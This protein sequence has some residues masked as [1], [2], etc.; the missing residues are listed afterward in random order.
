[1]DHSLRRGTPSGPLARLER[2]SFNLLY[3]W[4][5]AGRTTMKAATASATVWMRRFM[6]GASMS[7]VLRVNQDTSATAMTLPALWA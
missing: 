3:L 2:R 6:A 5:W 7:P 4:A 1:M